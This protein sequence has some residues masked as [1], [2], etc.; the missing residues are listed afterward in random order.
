MSSQVSAD[1]PETAARTLGKGPAP[2]AASLP[3]AVEQGRRA[4]LPADFCLH[5][6]EIV[7]AIHHAMTHPGEYRLTTGF[8]PIPRMAWA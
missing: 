6:N 1:H 8:D 5:N 2:R 4:H 7:L 3:A